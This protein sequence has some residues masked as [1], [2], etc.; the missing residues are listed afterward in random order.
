MLTES[1]GVG[2]EENSKIDN[3]IEC[4]EPDSENKLNANTS[5]SAP[6]VVLCRKVCF[7]DL[8]DRMSI[9]SICG[10]SSFGESIINRFNAL[11]GFFANCRQA[12]GLKLY[13]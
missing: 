3:G 11:R 8:L 5:L 1:V 9:S 4:P 7:S 6:P 10:R 13:F 2:L 12:A